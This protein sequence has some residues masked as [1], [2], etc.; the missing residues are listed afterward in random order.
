[1]KRAPFATTHPH[2]EGEEEPLRSPLFL[3]VLTLSYAGAC[4]A[5][6]LSVP[7][8]HGTY[9]DELAQ[10][11]YVLHIM[12]TGSPFVDYD[13]FFLFDADRMSGFTQARNYLFHPPAFYAV[14]AGIGEFLGQEAADKIVGLRLAN[15]ALSTLAFAVMLKV[16]AKLGLSFAGQFAYALFLLL[17][18][19]LTI[20]GGTITNSNMEMLGGALCTLGAYGVIAGKRNPATLAALY[21][22][23]ALAALAKLTAGLLCGIIL[24]W[25]FAVALRYEGSSFLRRRPVSIGLAI[26]AISIAPYAWHL[27]EYGSVVPRIPGWA[28]WNYNRWF[29]L[30]NSSLLE[31]PDFAAHFLTKFVAM[32]SPQGGFPIAW[33]LSLGMYLAILIGFAYSVRTMLT[34]PP[35]PTSIWIVGGGIAVL[36]VFCLNLATNYL[37]HVTHGHD[38]SAYPRYYLPLASILA[39][40]FATALERAPEG[41]PRTTAMAVVI[42]AGII[43]FP[44]IFF[45]L[46]S[47]S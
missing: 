14:M 41:W 45:L 32:W 21:S 28:E 6:A 11:S 43:N 15:V 25:A 8:F 40:A 4:I 38:I 24:A 1:M 13:R 10:F 12:E 46:S 42:I 23:F 3:A 17:N 29:R 16:G 5:Y 34:R 30:G 35:F 36:V 26:A 39:A 20:M 2:G 27:I 9:F 47:L 18:P 31:F 7:F 19:T 44:P 33:V 37:W 22:G